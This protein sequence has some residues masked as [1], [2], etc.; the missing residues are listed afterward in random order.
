MDAKIATLRS[1]RYPIPTGPYV[2]FF[3][4]F[5]SML[6]TVLVPGAV[7]LYF[8]YALL[9]YSGISLRSANLTLANPAGA[10][11]LLGVAIYLRCAWDFAVQGLGTPAPIGPPKKLV[12]TGPYRWL[13]NPMYFGMLLVLLAECLL[14]PVLGLSAYAATFALT[15]HCFVVFYEEPV[16]GTRFG[17]SFRDYR[18][19]VP[20]WGFAF[21]PFRFRLK[22]GL[23][24]FNRRP[25]R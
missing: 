1:V 25:R 12:V 13:R 19:K 24:Y 14:F 17:E 8:P 2:R 5:K 11:I 15:F 23:I 4:A 10:C 7:T 18:R 20:R 6:F 3:L 9:S 21:H 22:Q 16:L